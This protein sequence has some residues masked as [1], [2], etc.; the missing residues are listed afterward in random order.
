MTP[1]ELLSLKP[2]S[3]GR[4][5]KQTRLLERMNE[6]TALHVE[7]CEPYRRIVEGAFPHGAAGRLTDLPYL[8]VRIFKTHLLRSIPESE[9]Y[10]T[11][12]SSGTTGSEPSRIPLDVKTATIQARLLVKLLA[13]FVDKERRP[14]LIVDSPPAGGASVT[15]RYAAT[16]GVM[17][18]GRE[19]FFCLDESLNLRR[20]AL[21]EWLSK[22]RTKPI[23]VF[24]FTFMLWKHLYK[25]VRDGELDLAGATVLHTGGWKK[26]LDES[27][28]NDTFKAALASRLNVG[29]VHNFY[30]MAEQVGTVF[31]ECERGVLHASDGSD[32]IMRDARTWEEVPCGGSGLVQCLSAL[33][34]SYPGHS[35]LTEDIGTLLGE[36]DCACGRRGRIF[37]IVGRVPRAELRGCSD[38]RS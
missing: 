33:P 27:V 25:A 10:K 19:H 28:D 13:D 5:E 9:V 30:G 32:V 14:M 4:A 31:I 1:D 21:I 2:Y 15:A 35:L 3:L 18:V 37:R 7:R 11:L 38:T 22:T 34:T 24:G 6:L 17:S 12:T 8:P 26:L 23:V 29:R 20:D 16:L 36:D